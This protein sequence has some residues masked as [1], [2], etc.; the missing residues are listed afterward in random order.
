MFFFQ[1]DE[2]DWRQQAT[3]MAYA[4]LSLAGI[5]YM[6]VTTAS[7]E[8]FLGGTA[9]VGGAIFAF[10]LAAEGVTWHMVMALGKLREARVK[11]RE[12]MIEAMRKAGF[13][14]SDIQ[15][16]IDNLNVGSNRRKQS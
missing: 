12:D 4:I 1:W 3:I 8:A 11:G 7:P 13:S 10:A 9:D 16:A 14:E 5:I 15:K 6:I 2:S